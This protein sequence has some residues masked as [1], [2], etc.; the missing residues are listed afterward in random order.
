[1]VQKR[2]KCHTIGAKKFHERLVVISDQA[3]LNTK[4]RVLYVARSMRFPSVLI[5]IQ[6]I[7]RRFLSPRL[8][9]VIPSINN[10]TLRHISCPDTQKECLFNESVA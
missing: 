2:C 1:M 6:S 4:L 7:N 9:V 8:R 3:A 5:M 10:I